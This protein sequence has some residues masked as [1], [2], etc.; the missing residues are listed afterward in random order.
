M[1]VP[2]VPYTL[3]LSQPEDMDFVFALHRLTMRAYVERIWGWDD[4]EQRA[5]FADYYPTAERRIV[6]VD[7]ADV[8][9]LTIDYRPDAVFVV[10]IEILPAFQGRGLGAQI[11]TDII[12]RAQDD[13]V[14]IELQVLKINP[15]RRL[16][17]RLGFQVT[18]ETETHYLMR[19]PLE[20]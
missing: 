18:G 14:P 8:G 15:A 1:S 13:G 10:N 16:Y 9:A 11:L 19:C 4:A 2:P 7:G 6:V 17:Q 5:R 12:R 3:R 20:G